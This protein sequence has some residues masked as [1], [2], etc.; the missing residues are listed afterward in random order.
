MLDV[1]ASPNAKKNASTKMYKSLHESETR[2]QGNHKFIILA[3]LRKEGKTR[4]TSE[5]R[6]VS[7]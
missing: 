2:V 7:G 3:A 1:F 5:T 6:V 4:Q